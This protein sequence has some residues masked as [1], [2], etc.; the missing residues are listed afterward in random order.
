[1]L[2]GGAEEL[3]AAG[4]CVTDGVAQFGGVLAGEREF[5]AV[6]GDADVAAVWLGGDG[7]FTIR[8]LD[9][10]PGYS[11]ACSSEATPT[12]KDVY[13]VVGAGTARSEPTTGSR[14]R[15]PSSSVVV[16]FS[17]AVVVVVSSLVVVVVVVVVWSS[18]VVVVVV[19]P[20]ES[21]ESSVALPDALSSRRSPSRWSGC[22]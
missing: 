8:E 19:S 20:S 10:E 14:A 16:V 6:H 9:Q 13:C 7:L 22:G 12:L 18:L 11:G 4:Q 15:M 2:A 1:V 3:L 5:L 17:S 21:F